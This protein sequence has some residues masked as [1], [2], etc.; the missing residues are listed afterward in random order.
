MQPSN[1]TIEDLLIKIS[2]HGRVQSL[3]L[4]LY[5][6]DIEVINNLAWQVLTAVPLTRKQ[7]DLAVRILR[8]YSSQIKLRH[9]LDI[10]AA[11]DSP[12]YK[13]GIREI[14][15]SKE[16]KIVDDTIFVKFN[17]DNSII[18]QIRKYKSSNRGHLDAIIWNPAIKSWEFPLIEKNIIFLGKTLVKQGF[19]ADDNFFELY[20]ECEK[21][22][23][24][25]AQY[26]SYISYNDSVT[27]ANSTFTIPDNIK[28]D[29]LN[30]IFYV[31]R[32]AI[33]SY[34]QLFY[35]QCKQLNLEKYL[36]LLSEDRKNIRDKDIL[37]NIVRY[38]KVLFILSQGNELN[39]IKF[40]K[41]IIEDSGIDIKLISTLT[42]LKSN[43]DNGKKYNEFIKDNLWNNT[44]SD[45]TKIVIL[46]DKLPKPLFPYLNFDFIITLSSTVT[47]SYLKS[48]MTD[49]PGI[50]SYNIYGDDLL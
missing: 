15:R 33:K 35:N 9:Q 30:V 1:L 50:I 10:D 47:H 13:Y 2:S 34:D 21:V 32:L 18:D 3:P 22:L 48:Y 31:K 26:T 41:T 36:A 39:S 37:K 14:D 11:L 44:L 45:Q 42:R 24:N 20:H 28:N 16:I 7:A 38:N 29:L 46:S 8:K 23:E 49:H 40:I 43:Y 27:I 6:D 19:T 25:E 4:K 12:K 5:I 17:F